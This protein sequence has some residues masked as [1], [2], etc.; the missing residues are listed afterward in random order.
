MGK[1]E[2]LLK[3]TMDFTLK[4][5][6][7]EVIARYNQGIDYQIRFSNSMID[8]MK[9]W[10]NDK[11]E[12]FLV[13]DQKTTQIE[14]RSP[15][16]PLIEERIL[17]TVKFLEHLP[18]NSLY[19]GME[20]EK[21]PYQNIEGL[22]DSRI[23]SFPDKATDN[24]NS[25][26]NSSL[27]AGAKKVAGVLYFG[28]N[29]TE[30]L[31][32]HDIGG[33]YDDSYYRMTVRSFVDGESSGQDIVCGRDLSNIE[34][35]FNSS[36]ENSGKLASMAVGGKQGIGGKYDVILS[37]TVAANIFGQITDAANPLLVMLGMSPVSDSLGKKIAPDNL[38]IE[39]NA[40]ISDGLGSRPFDVEG[41]PANQTSIIE[42]GVL[43]NFIQNTST[44]KNYGCQSTANSEF[45]GLGI[46]SKML[47]PSPSNMVY[48]S[49]DYSLDEIIA[50]SK[51]PTIYI[52]SNWYTRFTNQLEGIFST[53]PRD[54]LFLIENGEIVKPL[55]KLRL[56]DNLLRMMQNITAIGKD[57]KQINWWE[58]DTPTF[59]PTIKV[60][61][62][63][64]TAATK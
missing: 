27:E 14:I 8:I 49:G 16:K 20:M 36:A 19:S 12:L 9:R 18:K 46:G 21:K 32:S 45:V 42:K 15:T 22:F 4:Q 55:R 34:K 29:S 47:A 56:A 64:I 35:K 50:E 53:I 2:D 61:N 51:K 1:F 23:K 43:K 60:A 48:K 37:P 30:L 41:R 26:I 24:V 57:V 7:D 54:G 63:N 6:V 31:T 10:E 11:L 40:L 25:A 13:K 58:V 33:N 62:C 17:H 28:Q 3:D 38:S 39:D 59:I 5:G 44:A 52:T